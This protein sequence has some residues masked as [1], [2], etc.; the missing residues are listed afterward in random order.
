MDG[1]RLSRCP[2]LSWLA[3]HVRGSADEGP[4][5]LG[6]RGV[7][8]TIC[9]ARRGH[10]FVRCTTRGREV[11]WSED[12]GAVHFMPA[13]DERR[14]FTMTTTTAFETAVFCIPR[15]HLD[16]YASAEGVAAPAEWRRLL[17]PDDAVLRSCMERLACGIRA[18]DRT[19]DGRGDEA[20]RR[21]I[22]RLVELTGGGVPDWHDDAS[23]FERRTL[24]HMVAAIDARLQ[25][26]PGLDEMGLLTGLSPSHFARKFRLSTGLSLQ[27][28]VN[29]RRLQAALG[30]LHDPGVPIAHVAH[31]LGFSSQ[32]HFTRLFS[33]L[34][35]MT[36]AKYQRQHRRTTA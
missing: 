7:C 8:H 13:D 21:L 16:A 33:R 18:H 31:E 24:D 26:P 17:A 23:V 15:Q 27:R 29:R 14:V 9:L 19:E 5:V 6:M 2:H 20:A 30:R 12:A 36:P 25:I 3:F 35:G 28:F 4:L 34:T 11:R 32:S 10:H 1:A 22:L